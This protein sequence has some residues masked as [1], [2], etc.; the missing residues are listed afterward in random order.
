MRSPTGLSRR[1]FLRITATAGVLLA[2]GAGLAHNLA[3]SRQRV[4]ESRLLL[5]GLA[6][7]TL[8]S[9]Q[10]QQARVAI[11]AAFDRMEALEAIFSR[12]QPQSQLSRL[13]AAGQLSA[14]HPA[15][16]EVLTRAVD[17]GELTHGAFDITIEPV[18]R[19]YR[20]HAQNGELPKASAVQAA[21]Q[22]VD[23]R[24]IEI[25]GDTVRLGMAGMAI[26][27][28]GIA[29]GYIVDQGAAALR[30]HGFESVLVEL[31]GDLH[32]LGG[33]GD[34]PWQIGIRQPTP[35]P[36]ARELVAQ[37]RGAALATSGDYL[38]TFT[39][40]RRLHHILEPDSG[41]SPGELASASVMA[42]TTCDADALSTA[43]LVM[44][45]ARGLDLID[46]L[47][48]VEALVIAKDGAVQPTPGFPLRV[49]S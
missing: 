16:R 11:T 19:L 28:D 25:S 12:F 45:A 49:V 18:H 4:A 41:L 35:E 29:K 20:Q 27:L 32:T 39:P 37:L 47:A 34:R 33:A 3:A 22:L 7:I 17:Y 24:Q 46:R 1:R 13:N 23:Y 9:D 6:N 38:H 2:G 48:G 26:T 30:E 8:I 44:G 36:A 31:G 15:L 10:P 40:D 5:G 42:T 21:R 43:L 14:A